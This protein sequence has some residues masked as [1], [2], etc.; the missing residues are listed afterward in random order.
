VATH[1]ADY[2]LVGVFLGEVGKHFSSV[3]LFGRAEHGPALDHFVLL[4]SHLRLVELPNYTSLLDLPSVVR[5]LSG[6]TARFWKRLSE[7]DAVLVFGPHPFG[8]VLAALALARRRRVV[9]GVRQDTLA[10]FRERLPSRRWLPAML[11]VHAVDGAHRLLAHRLPTVVAGTEIARRYGGEGPRLLVMADSAVPQAEVATQ[12][13]ERD[14]SGPIR[15]LTVGRID[16]EK[17]PLLVV[18][19]LGELDKLDPG[20]FS[21]TWV[22]DGPLAEEVRTRARALGVEASLDLRGWMPFGPQVLDLYRQAHV[23]VHVSWTEGVPRVLYEALACATPIVATDVGGV[24][25]ALDAGGAGLLVPPGDRTALVAAIRRLVAEPAMRTRL[26]ER[27]LELAGDRSL[28][29]QAERVA[30]F[31]HGERA[32]DRGS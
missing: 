8:L 32:L 3:E 4:P 31:V 21:L 23:F 2:A 10:Y 29:G 1:P 18:D 27:G 24:R 7:L 20:R 13:A 28:E 19:A 17:N 26:V 16:P 6:T 15:L 14:W 11:V 30:A 9:L 5:A 22:G 25:V 12:P